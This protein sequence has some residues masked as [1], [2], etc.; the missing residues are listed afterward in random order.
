MEVNE[1]NLSITGMTCNHCA[2]T[3]NG[4]IEQE[5]GGEIHVDYL[6]GEAHFNLENIEKLNAIAK[7]LKQAGYEANM[8]GEALKTSKYSS[9]EK[10][11]FLTIPFSLVL[12]SHMFLPMHWLINDA[13]IQL[14][15]CLPVFAIGV[16]HFGSSSYQSLRSGT[17][18]M[19]I[20][21]L[22]G[23]SSACIYSLVGMFWF[24]DHMHD[25]LFFETTSTIITLVLLG[26]VIEEKAVQRTTMAL[27][28]IIKRRPEKAKKLI[29]NGLNQDLTIINTSEIRIGDVLL[30]NSGDGVP[31]DGKI[32]HG[33]IKVD[34]SMLTGE[35]DLTSLERGQKVMSGSIVSDG[36]ATIEALNIEAKSTLGMIVD[37]AKR[38]RA[39]K[40]QIQ[41]LADQI[42]SWF[43]P[44]VLTLSI[45]SWAINFWILDVGLSET[46]IRSIA[47]LV[48]ACP[49][50][51][52]LA[53]PT[54]VSVGLGLA[55]LRGIIIK[56]ASTFEAINEA[57]VCIFDKTGTL[58][59]GEIQFELFLEDTSFNEKQIWSYIYELE[60]HSSHPIARS[61]I[62]SAGSNTETQVEDPR[63]IKGKGMIA[64]LENKELRFGSSSFTSQTGDGDLFLTLDNKLIAYLIKKEELKTE[65]K[66][67]IQ[68]I[69]LAHKNVILLSGDSLRKTKE[70]ADM[71]EIEDFFG[72]QLPEEKLT[73]IKNKQKN[74]KVI[75]MGDGINDAPALSASSV[76]ISI[77]TNN[78]LASE[79]ASVVIVGSSLDRLT[80]LLKIS[81]SVVRTIRQ[82]L[83]WAFSYNLIAIPLAALGFLDPMLAALS[84]AFSDVVVIGNSL[85]LKLALPKTLD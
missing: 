82:N 23:S 14:F 79:S 55:N 17:I 43:V 27:K 71:L 47:I 81:S 83:F 5:G 62:E 33:K 28:S 73:F 69:K 70:I 26:Y 72:D 51:M 68:R 85:R 32:I 9:I 50:A 3:V 13:W 65:A 37:L 66:S 21:I 18:N 60:K 24:S 46:L 16:H 1:V 74:N 41:K 36:N 7:R 45:L 42:S 4:I 39:D 52:G 58:T 67:V 25:F 61:L 11:L 40:P 19:D 57:S 63:E 48:I 76:G 20:L 59:T 15:L 29:Q 77:G 49:C 31:V 54:A 8:G 22:I 35:S 80:D 34:Q 64:Q 6:M 2:S 53:T 38:S 56:K 10:K 12:F 30:I 75:M 44:A 78:A 84:M